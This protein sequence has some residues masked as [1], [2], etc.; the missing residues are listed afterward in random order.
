MPFKKDFI[1]TNQK[2]KEDAKMDKDKKIYQ[3]LNNPNRNNIGNCVFEP[4][5]DEIHIGL[6]NVKQILTQ[7]TTYFKLDSV[8]RA[9]NVKFNKSVF[10]TIKT[11]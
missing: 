4:N 8:K 1:L 3:L 6:R 9:Q 7:P 5:F 2:S 11:I 10:K